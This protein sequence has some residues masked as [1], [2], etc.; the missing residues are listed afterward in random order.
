MDS[1]L[2]SPNALSYPFMYKEKTWSL[3]ESSMITFQ[4]VAR[5]PFTV[6]ISKGGDLTLAIQ[7]DFPDQDGYQPAA[8]GQEDYGQ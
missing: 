4:M 7:C 3:F 2:N 5:P 6:K 8:E 1:I